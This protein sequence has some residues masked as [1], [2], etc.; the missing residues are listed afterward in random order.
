VGRKAVIATIE[1]LIIVGIAIFGLKSQLVK[2]MDAILSVI[3][4]RQSHRLIEKW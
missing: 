3:T 1:M 4:G 2:I